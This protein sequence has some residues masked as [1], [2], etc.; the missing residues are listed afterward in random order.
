MKREQTKS[1][2]AADP[3]NWKL[4]GEPG[5]QC[6]IR[7]A[8]GVG[9]LKVNAG[10]LGVPVAAALTAMIFTTMK[11]EAVA[12]KLRGGAGFLVGVRKRR[13]TAALQAAAARRNREKPIEQV[14]FNPESKEKYLR[15]GL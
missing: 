5:H 4:A 9:I 8:D 10:H 12:E 13:S 6:E 7:S 11:A 15:W 14:P 2:R 1:E 3:E